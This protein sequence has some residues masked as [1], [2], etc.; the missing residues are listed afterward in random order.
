MQSLNIKF[1][2]EALQK[3]ILLTNRKKGGCYIVNKNKTLEDG[4]NKADWLVT[5]E[6]KEV[7][8]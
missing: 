1:G 5:L 4:E 3:G 6:P 2:S 7:R 8:K